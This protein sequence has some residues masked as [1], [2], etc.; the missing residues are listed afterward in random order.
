MRIGIDLRSLQNDSQFRGIGTYTRCLVK[1]LLSLDK[2]NEYIFFAFKNRPI[3]DLL[4]EDAFKHTKVHR[5]CS[6]RKRFVWLLSQLT[7]PYVIAR[8]RLDIFHSPEYIIPAFSHSKRI[9]TVHDFI[10]SDYKRYRRKNKFIRNA[11]LALRNETIKCAH[12]V[13][14]VSEYTK[15]K[16]IELIGIKQEKIKVIYEAANEVFRPIE[17]HYLLSAIKT[18][19]NIQDNCV[20][21]VGTFDH[22]KNIDNLLRAFSLVNDKRVNLVIAGTIT[23]KENFITISKL[24]AQLGLGQRVN[25]VGHVPQDELAGFY[26]ISKMVISVSVYE[27]FGLPILEA[28]ACGKPVIVAKNTSM[29]EIVGSCGILVDPYNTNEIASAIDRLLAQEELSAILEEK[30]L[31]RAKEFSWEKAA[32]QTLSL[33]EELV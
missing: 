32:R 1:S 27:G 6:Q 24:I 21:Y 22:H 20:L 2:K 29:K 14:A 12:R 25:I 9:I 7:F 30:A 15:N 8:H 19:Y 26:N 11:Y 10:H 3:P 17:D 13:I 23:D 18:K 16:I 5:I 31:S 28:M 33:Y 4:L